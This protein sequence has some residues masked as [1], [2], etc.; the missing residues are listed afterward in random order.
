[1][2]IITGLELQPRFPHED[3]SDTNA[4]LLELMLA[5]PDVVHQGHL[6]GE[7]FSW[8]FRVGHP[9]A[10]R[11]SGRIY[12]NDLHIEAIDHG[13]ASFEAMAMLV[14]AEISEDEFTVNANAVALVSQL[15]EFKLQHYLD[16]ALDS[17]REDTPRAVEVVNLASRRFYGALTS[18]A[19]LGA[20]IARQF[21]LDAI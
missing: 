2:S 19:L 9:A 10:V 14:G 5:N 6:Q 17:F 15:K 20:A 16:F 1:M 3:L 21:E 12:E 4:D 7:R 18:Y 13:V 8:A 11:G